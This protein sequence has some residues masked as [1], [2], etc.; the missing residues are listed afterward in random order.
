MKIPPNP[1]SAPSEPPVI[2]FDVSGVGAMS[3]SFP[4][5]PVW[6]GR[7]GAD[8]LGMGGGNDGICINHSD[9]RR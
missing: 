1:V 5:A 4:G 2:C 6:G 7:T 3:L 8:G 9:F